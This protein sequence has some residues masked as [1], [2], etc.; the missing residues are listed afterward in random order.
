MTT[1]FLALMTLIPIDVHILA[2]QSNAV[3]RATGVQ[4]GEFQYR[5]WTRTCGA[6]V[7]PPDP[8]FSQYDVTKFGPEPTLGNAL[9]SV[10]NSAIFHYAYNATN[11]ADNWDPNANGQYDLK[12]YS[13]MLDFVNESL[14][15]LI[16][17]G[18]QPTMKGFFWIQGENDAKRADHS[19]AYLDN[20][21]NFIS[22]VTQDLGVE[23][24][25]ATLLHADTPYTYRDTVRQAQL[26]SNALIVSIDDQPL[27]ADQIH[28]PEE[29]QLTNGQRLANAYLGATTGD[30]DGNG[31]TN[32]LDLL[33]WQRGPKPKALDA[34]ESFYGSSM[35][36][37]LAAT[38]AAVP[39]PTTLLLAALVSMGLLVRSRSGTA[40]PRHCPKASK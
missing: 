11:L 25:V 17:A 16:D 6:G 13:D 40:A 31:I 22:A 10:N 32:G 2:G 34:W 36:T 24:F 1:A 23:V 39:E 4:Q 14:Q 5:R 30:W 20:L 33:A 19:S 7:G 3:D 38:S 9:Q 29:T 18:Y 12:L 35:V 37:P 21:N 28:H 15:Q 26:E 8:N 27:N